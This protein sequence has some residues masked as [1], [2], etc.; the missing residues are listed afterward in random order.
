ML[1]SEMSLSTP[2]KHAV[3][4]PSVMQTTGCNPRFIPFSIPRMV[5]KPSP[6]ES[7]A[8]ILVKNDTPAIPVKS[9]FIDRYPNKD[10]GANEL[11]NST[12]LSISLNEIVCGLVPQKNQ[13][14][15]AEHVYSLSKEEAEAIELVRSEKQR[16]VE[17]VLDKENNVVNINSTEIKVVDKGSRLSDHISKHGYQE[18][19][20]KT[21][22]GKIVHFENTNKTKLK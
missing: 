15:N 16:K 21:Q 4:V 14:T 2:P 5:K 13:T 3:I 1:F 18:I 19:T 7:K 17:I 9:A 11:L 6:K 22:D 20:I 12:H 8:N 10:D